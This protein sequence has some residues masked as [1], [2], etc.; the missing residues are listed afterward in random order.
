MLA[1]L[2]KSLGPTRNMMVMATSAAL[3]EGCLS[4]GGGVLSPG[5]VVGHLTAIESSNSINLV[6]VVE[7]TGPR[8]GCTSTRDHQ[9]RAD[10]RGLWAWPGTNRTEPTRT[11]ATRTETTRKVIAMAYRGGQSRDGGFHAGELAVQ[12]RAGVVAEAARLS[13][14]LGP[15][16]LRGG[17]V[18]FLDAR[19]FAVLTAR[20]GAGR[21]WT[22]PLTGGPGFLDATSPE[23]LV[24]HSVPAPGD[25][26]HELPA[27]QPVGLLVIDFS[28]RRRVR[29]N[30]TLIGVTT[31]GLQIQ[32][33]QA[34][35]NCPQYIQK[36]QLGPDLTAAGPARVEHRDHLSADDADLITR[37]DTFFIGTVHPS[38]GADASHRGGPAGFVRVHRDRLWWPDY[39]GNNMFNTFGNLEIDPTAAL[40]FADFATGDTLHLS[41]TAGVDWTT[42]G[43]A[44]DDTGRQ[45]HF[46]PTAIVAPTAPARQRPN[47]LGSDT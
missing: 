31:A 25:P 4:L 19:T 47:P 30:G 36:R 1:P 17:M 10:R 35:G 44:S 28:A 33:E 39:R 15:A 32:V 43:A 14:M 3:L 18:H 45:A 42:P 24:I 9:A 6:S 40:L 26:L 29:L 11:E 34:Y 8:I 5:E 2:Q 7:T 16:E 46:D 41:G 37:A 23:T 21:L 38:R 20:D 27:E 22:S 13:G 12:R